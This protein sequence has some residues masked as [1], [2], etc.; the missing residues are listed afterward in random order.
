[1]DHEQ[2]FIEL[3]ADFTE[4]LV[5]PYDVNEAL[6][7]LAEKLTE[8]LNLAGSG[9]TLG[10]DGQVRAA[11]AVPPPLTA[12]EQ[13][14]EDHQMGPCVT[15]YRTGEVVTISDLDAEVS[16][17]GYHDV[18]A[19]VGVRAVAGIP[20]KL[21]G[22]T[23]GALN[24]YHAEP[25]SWVESD[26]LAARVMSNMATAYLIHSSTLN[27]KTELSA[28]LQHALDSRVLIEQAKGV[29]AQTHAISMSGAYELLRGHARSHGL[30]VRAV[31]YE[32]VENGLRL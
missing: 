14:Q 19:Q 30:K 10:V 26:L 28:Q 4:K 24:M 29:L 22:T 11:T 6:L 23:V 5:T 16:W 2:R 20:M 1:M 17:P 27:Q 21:A 18:A 31:A 9:V 8:L 7:D 15:A 3:A 25:H 32:V 12:L 13:F